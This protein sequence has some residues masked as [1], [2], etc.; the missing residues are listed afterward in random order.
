MPAP[1]SITPPNSPKKHGGKTSYG[2][3]RPSPSGGHTAP[4]QSTPTVTT[5]SAGGTV[6]SY[7]PGASAAA[8]KQQKALKRVRQ[9]ERKL[10]KRALRLTHDP[11][12]PK[13]NPQ[14]KPDTFLGKK[15]VG[16]P[17]LKSLRTG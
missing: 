5:V 6:K 17:T 4:A 7:G 9:I 16:T 15:T 8:S 10:Q 3:S 1:V 11:P 13:Y 12:K 2:G 14:A